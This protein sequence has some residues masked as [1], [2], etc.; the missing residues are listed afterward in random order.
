M[1]NWAYKNQKHL[2]NRQKWGGVCGRKAEI[3][4]IIM[5]PRF[6]RAFLVVKEDSCRV[7]TH[8]CFDFVYSFHTELRVISL[9]RY[10]KLTR[11]NIHDRKRFL[12]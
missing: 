11:Y 1:Q 7:K 2:K 4:V 9:S 6:L 3:P 12:L 5:Y 8:F 10:I